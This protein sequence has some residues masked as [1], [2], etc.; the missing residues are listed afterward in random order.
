[1]LLDI[2]PH[3]YANPQYKSPSKYVEHILH[4]MKRSLCS[5]GV[6]ALQSNQ[7]QRLKQVFQR[8]KPVPVHPVPT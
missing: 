4:K 8:K 6:V 3:L 1:M 2:F 7:S 5:E